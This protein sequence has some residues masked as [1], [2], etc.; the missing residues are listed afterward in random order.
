M[1]FSELP[2]VS[3]HHRVKCPLCKEHIST[4]IIKDKFSCP[5]CLKPLKSN[6]RHCLRRA[7]LLSCVLYLI[8][9][10]ALNLITMSETLLFS[11]IASVFPLLSGVIYYKKSLKITLD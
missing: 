3:L 4:L 10:I 9:F 8:L 6:H 7:I 5:S 1:L 11:L 2:V